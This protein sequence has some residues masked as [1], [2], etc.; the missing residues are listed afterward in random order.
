M[1]TGLEG[2]AAASQWEGRRHDL[3]DSVSQPQLDMRHERP[4]SFTCK[5]LNTSAAGMNSRPC[6]KVLIVFRFGVTLSAY[7]RHV[8][9]GSHTQKR[10]GDTGD[11]VCEIQVISSITTSP[12]MS[13][14]L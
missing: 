13:L 9:A 11:L 7:V 2:A 3:R 14:S 12:V 4:A 5:G 6:Y 10:C 8:T 1:M